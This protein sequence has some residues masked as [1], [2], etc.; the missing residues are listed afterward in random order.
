M[1]EFCLSTPWKSL[2]VSLFPFLFF[3]NLAKAEE[4]ILSCWM[5]RRA[6][7]N[8]MWCCHVWRGYLWLICPP[9]VP[10]QAAVPND[11]CGQL[12]GGNADRGGNRTASG[13]ITLC[14]FVDLCFSGVSLTVNLIS[15]NPCEGTQSRRRVGWLKMPVL[16]PSTDISRRRMCVNSV[17][18]FS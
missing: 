5:C 13:L 2:S 18:L 9:C 6:Q 3:F 4:H 16:N 17:K 8:L 7:Q 15:C 10:Q 1:K 12:R 14:F 11:E